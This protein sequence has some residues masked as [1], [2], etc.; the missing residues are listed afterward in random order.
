MQHVHYYL[1][2]VEVILLS[3]I[4]KR[5]LIEGAPVELEVEAYD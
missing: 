3:C 5:M 1:S 4:C 2:G